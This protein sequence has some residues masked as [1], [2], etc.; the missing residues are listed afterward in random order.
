MLHK[1]DEVLKVAL[2]LADKVLALQADCRMSDDVA[3][4]KLDDC[5]ALARNIKAELSNGK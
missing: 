4:Y 3:C 2:V 5:A 1:K